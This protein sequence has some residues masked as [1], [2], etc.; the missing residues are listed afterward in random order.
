VAAPRTET[1]IARI[2]DLILSG[3]LPAGSRLPPEHELAAQ[4]GLSR[5][6]AR[7]AVRALTT[8]RVLDVRRG[9]GTYVTSLTPDLLLEGV[10][11]AVEL[12]RDDSVLEVLEVRR[13]LEPAATAQAASHIDA[14]GLEVL[15]AT[16]RRMREAT[17]DEQFV[18]ED[19]GFHARVAEAS[20]NGTM[21]ALLDGLSSRTLRVRVLR[22]MTSADALERTIDQH[23]AIYA[24]LA[25]GDPNLAHA[26]AVQHV[27]TTEAWLRQLLAGGA[28]GAG[29]DGDGGGA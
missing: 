19:A 23:E 10:G 25:A 3:R 18:A 15:R 1:A 22:A 26:L 5:N 8:A 14:A 7:E 20:G 11:A 21:A 28:G 29:G 6:T 27:V 9:D 12:M 24:A 2:R 13:Y 4:L 16:I 17:D